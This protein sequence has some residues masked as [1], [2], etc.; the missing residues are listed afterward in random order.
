M[1]KLL[2]ALT[3]N[4]SNPTPTTPEEVIQHIIRL[5]TQ[6]AAFWGASHGWAPREAAEL[7]SKSRLDRQVSLSKC[8]NI[9]I[10]E[11][12]IEKE[13]G[14]LILAWANLGSLVEGTLKLFLSVYYNDYK[15][16]INAIKYK[17]E[18]QDPDGLMLEKIRQFFNKN[19]LY[20]P[21]FQAFVEKVQRYRNAIHAFK[22]KDIGT[23]NHFYDCLR[24]YLEMIHDLNGRLPYPDE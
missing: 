20:S 13:D 23:V 6:L 1:S 9:W 4:I 7:M 2:Q 16:D 21:T 11:N 17:G 8:L 15:N 5:N 10:S 12:M 24:T 3:D 14:A 18:L 22:D 19:D